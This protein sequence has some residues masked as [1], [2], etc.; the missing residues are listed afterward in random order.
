[1]VGS[2]DEARCQHFY[3]FK[4]AAGRQSLRVLTFLLYWGGMSIA[5]LCGEIVQ[6]QAILD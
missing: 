6:A 4:E 2:I 1:M 3:R 5:V